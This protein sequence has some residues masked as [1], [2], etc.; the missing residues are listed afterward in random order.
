MDITKLTRDYINNPLKIINRKYESPNVNDLIELYINQN[1]KKEEICKY[2]N[3]S[4]TVLKK[5]LKQNNIKKPNKEIDKDE[6]YKQYIEEN[7]SRD[8]VA[9]YFGV[10]TSTITIYCRKYGIERKTQQQRFENYIKTMKNDYGVVN[11]FQLDTV[12]EK[13]KQTCKEKYSKEY[14]QSTDEYR[15]KVKATKLERYGDENYNNQG[16]MRETCLEKYNIYVP[17]MKQGKKEYYDLLDSKEETIKFIK[18][19]NIVNIRHMATIM[20]MKEGYVQRKINEYSLKYMFDYHKSVM[21]LE[22]Q[23]YI[24]QYFPNALNNYDLEKNTELDIYIPELNLGIEFDGNYWHSEDVKGKMAQYNKTS[25]AEKYGIFVYHIFEY[26][27]VNN[28]QK[29]L[30][31]LNNLLG[32]NEHSIGA[33]KCSVQRLNPKEK[34]QFLRENHLQG[35]DKCNIA[36]GLYYNDELVSVMTFT[37]P[38]FNKKYEWEL[39]RYACKANYN[40]SG[41]A[42]KL[43]NQ[44]IKDNNPKNIISYSDILKT[45]GNLYQKLGFKLDHISDPNYVWIKNNTNI[46]TRYQCQKHKLESQGFYGKSETDIMKA[47]GYYRFFDCG[48]KVWVFTSNE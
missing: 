31:Q 9:K 44:F 26:E 37:K 6:L 42:S 1:L 47:L 32:I 8:E 43:F 22:L 23:E 13:A 36:Y 39:S 12:K 5:F 3:I 38:R 18:E 30:N 16:K 45:K 10:N 19:N 35:E 33:R 28:R 34:N 24:K 2:F 11:C 40:I 15:R 4:D 14:Y 21:E 27:W 20:G 46:K 48:N 25:K 7:K 17:S 29:I 41:G